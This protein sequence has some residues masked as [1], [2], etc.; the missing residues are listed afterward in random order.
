VIV[1]V[2]LDAT[3]TSRCASTGAEAGL[4]G[5]GL[6][7]ISVRTVAVSAGR[8][9]TFG[10][11]AADAGGAFTARGTTAAGD[12]VSDFAGTAGALATSAVSTAVF[13][14]AFTGDGD[15]HR[16]P[17]NTANTTAPMSTNATGA[18]VGAELPMPST[19]GCDGVADFA[20]ARARVRRPALFTRSEIFFSD[21]RRNL[22]SADNR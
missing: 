16:T 14:V 18:L 1:T 3:A 21:S 7:A 15:D 12:S 9:V 6:G 10:V 17:T 19:G 4:V 13:S 20:L 5:D 8:D 2:S 11:T 22:R